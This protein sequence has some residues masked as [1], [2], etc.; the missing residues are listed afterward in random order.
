MRPLFLVFSM[1]TQGFFSLLFATHGMWLVFTSWEKHHATA[2]CWR[3]ELD[4]EVLLFRNA[5]AGLRDVANFDKIRPTS[6]DIRPPFHE[7]FVATMGLGTRA[8]PH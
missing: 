5:L 1:D 8:Q 6:F 7:C 4:L 3:F 2:S